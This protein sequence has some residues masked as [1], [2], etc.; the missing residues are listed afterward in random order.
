MGRTI[1]CKTQVLIVML[2]LAL[3]ACP[4]DGVTPTMTFESAFSLTSEGTP[5]NIG[6][7]AAPRLVDWDDDGA[8]D[9][10]VGGGDG[11]I[12]LFPQGSS[13]N[14]TNF[15]GASPVLASGVPIR[16][17]TMN[18]SVCMEDITGDGLP[19]LIAT[20]NDN[21]LRYYSNTGGRG[22]PEFATYIA[23]Q[24]DGGVLT[25][26]SSVGG[27]ME[28][29]DWD[30]DGLLD[31]LTGDF[32]GVITWYRNTG[33]PGTPVFGVPGVCM[34]LDGI[35]LRQS[36]N[37]HPR[38]VD[39]N[40]DGSPDLAYGINWGYVKILPNTDG[41]GMTNFPGSYS[42]LNT[43]GADLNIRSLNGDDTTPDFADLNGDGVL[44]LISGGKNGKLFFVPGIA[45]TSSFE[46]IESIMTAHSNDLGSALNTNSN[47]RATLFGL[48]QGLRYL[49]SGGILPMAE[50]PV[51]RDWYRAHIARHA[52]YLTK[53]HLDQE[54]HAYVPYLAGQV[55]VNLYES[56]PDSPNHRQAT[57]AACGFTGTYSNLLVDLG[58]LFIDNSLASPASQQALYDIASATPAELQIVE[59]VTQHGNLAPSTGKGGIN[60]RTGVNVFSIQVGDH[61]EGF[62][63]DVPD[64]RIDAFCAV[65]AHEINHNVENAARRR[66]PWFL[67]RKLDLIEQAAP[68][69]LVFRDHLVDDFGLDVPATKSNFLAS[70]YWDGVEEHWDDAYDAYWASGPGAPYNRHWLRDNLLT[71]IRSSQE[72]F[73]TLA[74]QYFTSS[75]VMLDLAVVRWNEGIL[76]CINQFLFFADVY[77][78]GDN[79]TYFYRVDT[80]ARV[81]R[82]AVALQRDSHGHISGLTTP[83]KHYEFRLDTEGNVLDLLISPADAVPPRMHVE[84]PS[85]GTLSISMTENPDFR[86]SV[87]DCTDLAVGDWQDWQAYDPFAPTS[88]WTIADDAGMR[89]YRIR[90]ERWRIMD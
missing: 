67:D 60:A 86:L 23:A 17:G 42:L 53:Q 34:Q 30:G 5:I 78:M 18:T 44:D 73:A 36:Y 79:V 16:I 87:E 45:Y 10:L 33:T 76:S 4:C 1:L 70:G 50:R 8:L 40:N 68:A 15:M 90:T 71:C 62:P 28:I 75:A 81:T 89:F 55:W 57:A 88:V 24:G 6:S 63:P 19:D 9:L 2:I 47:L 7:H 74:N 83:D 64:T 56:V 84:R 41:P 27:R 32:H 3:C 38:V 48:H 20:G 52:Q 80:A 46:R 59:L 25:L 35:V 43:E 72:S 61:S 65:V 49:T 51:I 66:Y 31:L 26:P 85:G 13:T 58:M 14:G 21:L 54:V 37:I 69:D 29:A 39:F 22:S 12:W 11:Y 77:A 82:T